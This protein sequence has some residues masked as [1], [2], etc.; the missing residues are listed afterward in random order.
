MLKEQAFFSDRTDIVDAT[1]SMYFFWV[2]WQ[3]HN[4]QHTAF[5]AQSF[6]LYDISDFFAV[7]NNDLTMCSRRKII[8]KSQQYSK[9]VLF[10]LKLL[11]KRF[12]NTLIR[13]NVFTLIC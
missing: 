9:Q 2:Y 11:E 5:L 3:W 13:S 1:G 6:A 4:T 12:C 8:P 7:P 10:N